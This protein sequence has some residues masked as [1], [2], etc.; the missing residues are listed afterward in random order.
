MEK[1]IELWKTDCEDCESAK[2][3]VAELE[4]EGEELIKLSE[5]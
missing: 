1:L 2:P 5:S 3:I 4:G